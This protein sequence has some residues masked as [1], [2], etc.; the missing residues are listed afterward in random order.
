MAEKQEQEKPQQ[1]TTPLPQIRVPVAI[2]KLDLVT[3]LGLLLSI[4]LIV[5]AIFIGQSDANF[6]NVPSLLIV[7]FGTITATCISYTGAELTQAMPVIRGSIFRPMHD[8][9]ALAKSMIDLASVARKRGVLM[10]SNYENQTKNEPFLKYAMGLVVDG[11]GDC[12]YGSDCCK[13]GKKCC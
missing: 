2:S 3:L 6:F 7:V 5:F 10:I 11:H 1:D 4:G 8:F 13:I 9:P 12:C